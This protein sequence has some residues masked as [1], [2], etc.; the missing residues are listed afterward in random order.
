[1]TSTGTFRK[2]DEWLAWLESL[3]PHEIVLGLERV[4]LILDRLAPRRAPLIINVA[5]TNGKGS[6]V[7]ML[8]ALLQSAGVRTGCYTSPHLVRYNERIRI[9]GVPVADQDIIDAFTDI[10]RVREGVPLTFFEF[11][12]LAAVLAFSKADLDAWILE[13]GMGGRLDAVNAI[14][15]HAV[16]ITNVSLDHCDWLGADVESIAREK[17]AVMRGGM[18]AIYGSPD[19]PAAVRD[20]ARK[21][22]ANLLVAGRDFS[23][24]EA[25]DHWTWQGKRKRLENL[26][27]PGL[28]GNVQLQNASAVL[29][30]VEA[31]IGRIVPPDL[32]S[33]ENVGNVLAETRLAGRFDVIDDRWILDV[34]HNPDA[35]RVLGE[36]L[37]SSVKDRPVTAIVGVLGDK[38]IGAIIEPLAQQVQRWVA[39][40]IEGSSRAAPA[41]K[42]ASAIANVTGRPCSVAESLDAAMQTSKRWAHDGGLVLVTGSFYVVGPALA[43]LQTHGD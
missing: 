18:P 30:L 27:K 12:T 26:R 19:I 8:E 32:L 6:S 34:A 7:A 1:M 43:W 21:V 25:G 40:P 41:W 39:V 2:L 9:E 31:V 3:S 14:D 42:T 33:T 11:G 4:R 16:L 24:E 28:V 38:D 15:P 17:A 22:G 10:E 5:G 36:Q 20:H 35:A 29:A 23:F 13:I 37:A